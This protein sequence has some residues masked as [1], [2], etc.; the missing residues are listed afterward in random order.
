MKVQLIL[1]V[2]STQCFLE[3]FSSHLGNKQTKTFFNMTK[4]HY[5]GLIGIMHSDELPIMFMK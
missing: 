3:T 1:Q 5:N 4:S 2:P